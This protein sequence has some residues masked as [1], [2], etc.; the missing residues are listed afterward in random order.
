MEPVQ[1]VMIVLGGLWG[2]SLL[3]LKGSLVRVHRNGHWLFRIHPE[4][5]GRQQTRTGQDRRDLLE[6]ENLRASWHR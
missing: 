6:K 4:L 1:K 2:S 3:G 5:W